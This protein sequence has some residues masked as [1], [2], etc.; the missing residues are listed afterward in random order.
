MFCKQIGYWTK[1]LLLKTSFVCKLNFLVKSQ[2][3]Q[4]SNFKPTWEHSRGSAEFLSQRFRLI[5]S[6]I[7][8]FS[9]DIQTN[10]ITN[11]IYIDRR[12]LQHIWTSSDKFIFMNIN[13]FK[14]EIQNVFLIYFLY[15]ART[16]SRF[17]TK[18]KSYMFR[19]INP[20]SLKPIKYEIYWIQIFKMLNFVFQKR[21]KMFHVNFKFFFSPN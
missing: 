18:T 10:K 12:I 1:A 17:Q 2:P 21:A 16:Y 13:H 15:F 5:S 20:L 19:Q 14:F 7:P 9:W 6:E 3:T 4:L 11:Y 8:E